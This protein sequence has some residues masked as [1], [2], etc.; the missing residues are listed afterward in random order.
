MN[1]IFQTSV[2][3]MECIELNWLCKYIKKIR[4]SQPAIPILNWVKHQSFPASIVKDSVTNSAKIVEVWQKNINGK[5]EAFNRRINNPGKHP[6][7]D[8]NSNIRK[9]EDRSYT[10]NTE[11]TQNPRYI[12]SNYSTHY[13]RYKNNETN[14]RC[15]NVT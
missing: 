12:L 7:I 8:R 13:D 1:H 9:N 15:R 10:R 14:S 2:L 6:H 5:K 11:P 3:I 4:S